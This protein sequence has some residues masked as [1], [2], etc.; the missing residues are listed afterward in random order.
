MCRYLADGH[1]IAAITRTEKYP[2]ARNLVVME[3][4]KWDQ[5]RLVTAYKNEEIRWYDWA[6]DGRLIFKVDR[7]YDDVNRGFEYVG[8]LFRAP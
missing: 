8:L 1:Y 6:R 7:D 2:A 3:A 4:G 5:A